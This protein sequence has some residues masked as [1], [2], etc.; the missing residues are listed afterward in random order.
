VCSLLGLMSIPT[1]VLFSHPELC[2]LCTREALHCLPGSPGNLISAQTADVR[3]H[4]L[5]VLEYWY[6]PLRKSEARRTPFVVDGLPLE[7]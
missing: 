7:F 4:I 1:W 5:L 2:S 3:A 6:M